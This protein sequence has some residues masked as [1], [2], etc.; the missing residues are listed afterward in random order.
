MPYD[1]FIHLEQANSQEPFR[2]AKHMRSLRYI[3]RTPD[4]L[5]PDGLPI[6]FVKDAGYEDGT[7][8]L[9]LTSPHAIPA[10]STTTVRPISSMAGRQWATSGIF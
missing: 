4:A 6:G 2:D 3:A 9:G 1:W 5:N 8:G 7:A 10:R